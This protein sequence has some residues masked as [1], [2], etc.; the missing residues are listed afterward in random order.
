MYWIIPLRILWNRKM[1]F[2]FIFHF[3]HSLITIQT[4]ITDYRQ[5]TSNKK[6]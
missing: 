1:I 6:E 5:F 2:G 4:T 3:K